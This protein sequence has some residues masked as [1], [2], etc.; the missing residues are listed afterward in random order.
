LDPV[1]ELY[2]IPSHLMAPSS[3]KSDQNT[4]ISA[5]MLTAIPEVDLGIE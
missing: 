2:Q 1:A 5:S 4:T 3:R